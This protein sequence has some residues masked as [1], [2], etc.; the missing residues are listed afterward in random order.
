M[1]YEVRGEGP[2]LLL[3]AGTGYPGATWLPEIVDRLT[4]AFT[5]IT[6]DHRGTG[7]TAGTPELYSTRLFAA[8]AL[9]L[10]GQ[11]GVG[12][13][14][15]VGHSMGGRVAQWMALDGP[16]RVR[17]L[18]LAASGPGQIREDRPLMRGIPLK[19]AM[20]MIERGYEGHMRNAITN[21]FFPPDFAQQ[22]PE[23]VGAL[24]SAFWSNRPNLENYLKHVIARQQHQTAEMLHRI[25][26]P[27]LVLVG[28]RDTGAGG[29]GSHVE[30]SMYLAEHLPNATLRVIPGAA[31][32]FF[33]HMPEAATS[34]IAEF[35][36]ARS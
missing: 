13:A 2:P 31:H 26:M 30:Q 3:V 15:V 22:R 4:E 27:A 7:S 32:G 8:D 21:S 9:G 24:I 28:D 16:E 17:T 34:A 10:L 33:W 25:T 12:P 11:L 1:A 29:T 19:H 6:F 35:V 5:V 18:I 20:S 23:V 36:A 14:H